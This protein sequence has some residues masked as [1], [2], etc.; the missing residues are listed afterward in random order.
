[1]LQISG[2]N[3]TRS[4]YC[5]TGTLEVPRVCRRSGYILEGRYRRRGLDGRR[6]DLA[7]P[8]VIARRGHTTG[9]AA[10]PLL[11]VLERPRS[12][13]ATAVSKGYT[14][15]SIEEG[16]F[17]VFLA[18]SRDLLNAAECAG[19]DFGMA[20]WRLALRAARPGGSSPEARNGARKD[21]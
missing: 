11:S 5:H 19:G 10:A 2:K 7:N 13:G 15:A 9:V 12:S 6:D 20:R 1:M 17:E 16:S 14:R 4:D 8:N 21:A 3:L 18:V